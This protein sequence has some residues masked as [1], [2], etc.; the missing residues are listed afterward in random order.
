MD[1]LEPTDMTRARR[2]CGCPA[3]PELSRRSFLKAAGV[4][5]IVAGLA[6]EG[7]FTRMAFAGTLYDGDVLVV[8]SLRGGFDSLQAIVP[9]GDA[10]YATWRPNIAIPQGQLLPLGG[11]FGLHPAMGS[12]KPFFDAGDLGMIHA[13]GMAEPNR[14][15]FSAMEEMERAA[16]GSSLR[17]GWLDRV[18]GLRDTGTAFQASQLGSN[19]ASSAFLGPSQELAMW[20]V[21]SFELSG[22]GDA[23][24]LA[25]WSTALG[26]LHVDAPEMLASPANTAL[27]A[28]GT[29]AN[30]QAAGYT[31]E[32]GAVYPDTGLGD[33]LKDVARL[34]KAGVGL[35]VAA[36]DYGDWDMHVGQGT[37][38]AGW[39]HDHLTELSDA[40]AA[41]G[42]D[43]GAGLDNVTLVT[44][45][46]FGRR[47]EENGSGGTDHGYGQAV[48]MMGGGVKGGQVHG[49]WPGLAPGNLVD[50]D[51]NATTDYRQVLAEILEKRCGAASVSDI[52]P[53]IGSSRPG[54]VNARV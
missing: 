1:T 19:T 6:S 41:F 38:D 53:E 32:F 4:A 5:G 10:D 42:T 13:V 12:L 37:F 48:L 46:E 9:T 14:S 28:I 26:G 29:A 11:I 30:L 54:V 2:E 20:S 39:M 23:T 51:L 7:M 43:L 25:R 3:G 16:P 45:T 27:G 31:P 21:D 40:L 18:L 33:A 24:E 17:T 15:H 50:G 22:A 47:V 44:L 8:L 49:A 35:Q 52:F 34:I 36:V